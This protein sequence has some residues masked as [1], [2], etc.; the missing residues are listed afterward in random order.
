[1]F[2]GRDTWVLEQRPVNSS[3]RESQFRPGFLGNPSFI[4]GIRRPL[5]ASTTILECAFRESLAWRSQ[6]GHHS[7]YVPIACQTRPLWIAAL[8]RQI[9]RL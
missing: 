6:N 9:T 5:Q 8:S 3:G 2:N 1:M 7:K 4:V